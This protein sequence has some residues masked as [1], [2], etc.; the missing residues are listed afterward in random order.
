[1]PL[2]P[3]KPGG[4]SEYSLRSLSVTDEGWYRDIPSDRLTMLVCEG[5]IFFFSPSKVEKLF[6]DV[7]EYFGGGQFV[8]D[9]VGSL[10][11]KYRTAPFK[12]TTLCAKWGVDD[13]RQIEKFHPKLK[14]TG[15]IRWEDYLGNEA[16]LGQSAPPLF[17]TWTQAMLAL[18]STA[19]FKDALQVLRFEFGDRAKSAASSKLVS[20]ST[21]S[22]LDYSVDSTSETTKE[23]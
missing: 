9:T 4:K 11:V 2:P 15:R 13:A 22:I 21:P 20:F 6:H 3:T 7:V 14:M 17:G 10:A 5:L 16:S 8:F 1:M 12:N 23:D 19:A 18:K